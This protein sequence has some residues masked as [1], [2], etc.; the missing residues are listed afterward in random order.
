[1]TRTIKILLATVFLIAVA[2]SVLHAWAAADETSLLSAWEEAQKRDPK[3]SDFRKISDKHYH[4]KTEYFP[5][6]GEIRVRPSMT[7]SGPY[8]DGDEPG[9]AYTI[10]YLEVELVNAP[11]DFYSVYGRSYGSWV[12]Q[13]SFY[14]DHSQDR[15]RT[16]KEYAASLATLPK[17]AKAKRYCWSGV[18]SSLTSQ[19]ISWVV[20]LFVLVVFVGLATRKQRQMLGKAREAT[21]ES[22]EIM[23]KSMAINEENNRVLKEML[24]V[25]KRKA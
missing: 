7:Q 25:L 21:A 14:Y 9:H 12:A 6:D 18:L 4:L 13:N 11:K 17:A 22:L 10:G 1:M 19:L 5:F 16:A 20:F 15:W 2:L 24:E 8:E 3:I 23:R